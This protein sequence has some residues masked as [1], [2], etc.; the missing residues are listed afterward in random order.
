MSSTKLASILDK[1]LSC[2]SS[3]RWTVPYNDFSKNSYLSS[4]SVEPQEPPIA[5]TMAAMPSVDFTFNFWGGIRAIF[6]NAVPSTN[7]AALGA[8]WSRKSVGH[9]AARNLSFCVHSRTFVVPGTNFGI[10]LQGSWVLTWVG[11]S[12]SGTGGKSDSWGGGILKTV[13]PAH[14][15]QKGLGLPESPLF[16][17]P[18]GKDV[19]EVHQGSW[20]TRL[21]YQCKLVAEDT[22]RQA[23]WPR[24]ENQCWMNPVK[25]SE[26]WPCRS[27]WNELVSHTKRMRS[28]CFDSPLKAP[29]PILQRSPRPSHHG[30]NRKGPMEVIWDPSWSHDPYWSHIKA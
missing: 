22:T 25:P 14:K 7:N 9:K 15:I 21:R 8:N 5:S 23:I 20:S 18:K 16:Q 27:K 28:C 6:L 2:D 3:L 13:V 12:S 17:L 4:S 1:K 30:L 29:S 11:A 24:Q 26:W 10:W 19:P